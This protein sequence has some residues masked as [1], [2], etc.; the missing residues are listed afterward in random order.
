MELRPNKKFPFCKSGSSWLPSEPHSEAHPLS[1]QS[2]LPADAHVPLP[3][4]H[5]QCTP[6][7]H[8]A[9]FFLVKISSLMHIRMLI[10]TLC[11]GYIPA[12]SGQYSYDPF[13]AE[14]TTISYS[15]SSSYQ[16]LPISLLTFP[17]LTSR[18]LLRGHSSSRLCFPE[19]GCTGKPFPVPNN[20]NF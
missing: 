6:L 2:H 17:L 12:F 10:L 11:I 16:S 15:S 13:R 3:F 8:S 7:L 18:S 1:V 20:N 14:E 5:T 9:I 19:I 4:P